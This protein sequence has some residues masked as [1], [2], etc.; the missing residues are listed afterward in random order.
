MP[1]RHL[2]STA[3]LLSLSSTAATAA[4]P[5]QR[6]LADLRANGQQLASAAKGDLFLAKTIKTGVDDVEHVRFDRQYQGLRVIGGD[7]V[8]HVR[9]GR[10]QSVSASLNDVGRPSTTPVLSADQAAIEAGAR[11]DGKVDAVNNNGLVIYAHDTRPTLAYEVNVRGYHAHGFADRLLY[12]DAANGKLLGTDDIFKTLAVKGKA[13]TLLLGQQNIITRKT[14]SGRYLLQDPTRGN[15]NV[16][17]GEGQ[18]I[19]QVYDSA[20]I[21]VDTDNIW[22]NGK[23]S[24]VASPATDAHYGVGMT[25]DYYRNIH[26]RRGIYDDRVGVRS[27]VNVK[28]Q[29][30]SVV[31]GANAAWYGAPYN[32][33]AY[34]S[35]DSNLHPVVALDVA[36]HEMTHG[37][38]EAVNQL[39]YAN[40][41]GGLNEA[42]SDIMGTMVEFYANKAADPGDYLIGEKILRNNPNGAAALRYMFHPSA[43]GRSWDCYPTSG[44]IGEDPHFSSGPANLFFYLLAEGTAR[45]TFGGVTHKGV[46]CRP[47]DHQQATGSASLAGIGRGKARAIWYRAMD[48]YFTSGTTYPQARRATIKAASDLFGASSQEV[49]AVKAAWKAV[50]VN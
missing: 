11:F 6:A 36:G 23:E 24:D 33:M 22:G 12:I 49:A 29:F 16:R 19:D 28:F 34:G 31:T 50:N 30:G 26:N 14:S 43:D 10:I 40:D 20:K 17:D 5:A 7:I 35:G 9:N 18:L 25:W 37:V 15:G 45:K 3:L 44:F 38:T 42:S 4:G 32:F 2:L 48:L 39:I 41:A 46:T 13:H 1:R 47:G 27:V 8:A 21:M